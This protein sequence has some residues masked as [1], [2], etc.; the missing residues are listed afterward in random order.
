MINKPRTL[1]LITTAIATVFTLGKSVIH[2]GTISPPR[3]DY[4]FPESV[5]LSQWQLS[6]SEPVTPH[7][8]QTTSYISGNLVAGKH[9]RY[10][11]NKKSLDIE[12]RYFADTNGNLKDFITSQ[13]G[14][15]SSGL[16]QD[17]DGGFYSLY[18]NQNKAY[19]SACINPRGNS[20]LST[21]QFNRNLMIYDTR[22][23][24]IFPWLLGQAEFR[25]KRCLWAHLSMPLDDTAVD[26]QYSSLEATWFEW[27]DWWRSHFPTL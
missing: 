24:R 1:L 7:A 23:E 18:V 6:S 25:D 12:M 19:L 4:T 22:L 13:M 20:T 9:Y 17:Q 27:Y 8:T 3:N 10:R 2:P 15:F 16:K 14:E 5:T 11:Q 26:D 21:D